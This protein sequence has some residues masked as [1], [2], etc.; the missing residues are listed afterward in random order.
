MHKIDF[1][2]LVS[3]VVMSFFTGTLYQTSSEKRKANREY[4]LSLKLFAL[5]FSILNHYFILH[6][7]IS[8][9]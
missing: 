9:F 4:G 5:R 3:L 7:K 6:W 8:W 1:I 2:T